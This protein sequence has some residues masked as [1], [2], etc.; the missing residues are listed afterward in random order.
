[1]R[2]IDAGC[3]IAFTGGIS[4][5]ILSFVQLVVPALSDEV[6]SVLPPYSVYGPFVAVGTAFVARV[7]NIATGQ[8]MRFRDG[9]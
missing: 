8:R 6:W 2:L 3:F 4:L 1:M 5:R 9:R 7:V